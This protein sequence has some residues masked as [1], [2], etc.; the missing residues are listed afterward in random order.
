MKLHLWFGTV[1]C[2]AVS[3]FSLIL[4][5][6]FISNLIGRD[7][8]CN[9]SFEVGSFIIELCSNLTV[10]IPDGEP[11]G[12]PSHLHNDIHKSPH[13]KEI[14]LHKKKKTT[15]DPPPPFPLGLLQK[16]KSNSIPHVL[17]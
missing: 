5:D 16:G 11:R 1:V 3:C 15:I 9:K 12:T 6:G 10:A 2:T 13:L 8:S 7:Q 14:V 17:S 4:Y